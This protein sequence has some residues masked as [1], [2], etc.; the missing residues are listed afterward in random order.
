MSMEPLNTFDENHHDLFMEQGYVRLGKVLSPD[1]L[2]G[3]YHCGTAL[4]TT[5]PKGKNRSS[6]RPGLCWTGRRVA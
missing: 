3:S 6:I 1:G 2:A 5:A 4:R